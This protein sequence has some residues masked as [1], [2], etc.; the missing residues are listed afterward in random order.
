MKYPR[1][2]YYRMRPGRFNVLC[3]LL[4]CERR[5]LFFPTLASMGEVL[6][7][8]R[9]N[10]GRHLARLVDDGLI[11]KLGLGRYRTN[12]AGRKYLREC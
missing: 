3:E 10:V 12:H 8:T 1:D 7:C 2:A 4:E 11:D 5:H 6:G 9:Q